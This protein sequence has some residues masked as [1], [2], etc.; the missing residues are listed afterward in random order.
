MTG[1]RL[2]LPPTARGIVAVLRVLPRVSPTRA[3]L[4]SG[5]VVL[6]AGLPVL[7]AIVTGLLVGA[8]PG[9]VEQGMDSVAAGRMREW[10]AMLAVLVVVDRM[11]APLLR[12][13]ASTLGRDVD[14]YLQE[15]VLRA[16]ARPRGIAHL[17]DATVLDEVRIVRGLGMSAH[18]PGQT[19]EA[20]PEVLTEWLRALCSAAVLTAFHWWLGLLWLTAWPVAVYVMQRDY[21]R[22]G[23]EGFGQSSQLRQAEYLRDLALDP[24]PAKEVR[25]WGALDW[26]VLR[27]DMAWLAGIGPVREA[28]RPR[29]RVVL[30]SAATILALNAVSFVLLVYAAVQG[31]LALGALVVFVEALANANSYAVGDEHL[32]L[33]HAAVTV[34]KV[35]SLEERLA[36]RPDAPTGDCPVSPRVPELG[37]RY[38]SVSFRYPGTSREVLSGLD[39]TIPAGRSIAIVGDNGAGKTS[40]VKLLAGFYEPTAG[41]ITVDG[42]DL[43]GLDLAQWRARIAVLFQDFTRYHLSVRDNI[44]LGAP[45]HAHDIGMLQRAA[46]KVGVLD[47]VESLPRGWDTVLA[48]AYADGVDLS[49][50]QWQRIALAR[51]LFAVEA[52]AR[53]LVLDEP[54]AALDVRAEAELYER[55]LDL[56]AGLT[57]CL[58]S[59]RF[60]TVRR[61]DHIVVLGGGRVIEAGGHDEL[62][63]RNGRYA[64]LFRLQAGR[65]AH[66][67]P[68]PARS[69]PLP[70]QRREGSDGT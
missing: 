64:H 38:E 36:A 47:L 63:A 56:T 65:F 32:L 4:L 1:S 16:L 20:L 5:G 27:F 33:S 7:I 46:A 41:R 24:M 11:T 25:L 13:T 45:D 23:E 17:E 10:L 21:R 58:I 48:R 39:L 40:L 61:A 30:G 26:L 54:T 53:V 35:V 60:S 29:S 8:I 51:A 59:H 49:G 31:D 6:S 12:A 15:V 22:V 34:P 43:A 42:A 19:V 14:R 68:V 57:T 66:A 52:G 55:F 67:A 50:G 70:P 62:L 9:A 3:M 69:A 2:R 44:G 18:R 28:R 37:I